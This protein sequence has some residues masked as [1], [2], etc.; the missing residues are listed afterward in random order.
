[1][2]LASLRHCFANLLRFSGRDTRAQFWPYAFTLF[3][4]S[5]V[6]MQVFMTRVMNAV[7]GYAMAHPERSRVTVGTG[8]SQITV[9]GSPAELAPAMQAMVMAICVIAALFVALVASAVA[10]R[11]HDR[12][13]S[14]LWAALP[15]VPLATGIFGMWRMFGQIG[16]GAPEPRLIFL[17]F[18]NNLFYLAA[19][20]TL[21]VMLA[22]SGTVGPNDY[23]PD[24]ARD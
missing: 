4:I 24:P 21:V 18:L 23:G 7:A 16:Q 14:G 2:F 13:S 22:K 12:G 3:L 1:M 5:M 8:G 11:L 10:R 6:A 20:A 19:L 9:H 17:L 15:V